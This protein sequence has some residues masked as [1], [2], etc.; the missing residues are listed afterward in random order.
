MKKVLIFTASTGG[1][2]NQAASSLVEEFKNNGYEAFKVDMLKETSSVLNTLITDGYKVLANKMPKVYGG[3]YKLSDFE[4]IN[5]HITSPI[6]KVVCGEINKII[7][8]H[9]PDLI[10]GTHPFIVDIVGK[11]KREKIIDIP[12]ISIVT[13]FEAHQTYINKYVDAYI[14][15]SEY[16]CESLANRGIS[17]A[18]LYPYGIPVKRVFLENNKEK[19]QKDIFQ[20]LL[21]GGS[22]GVKSMNKVFK[23]LLESSN[24]FKLVIVCGNDGDLKKSLESFI[25]NNPIN[26]QIK[27]YGFTDKIAELMDESDIIITKPGGLTVTESIIKN[28]P[29]IIP[30][31]IP[32]QEEENAD[33]LVKSG[34][35]IK[36]S[37]K[38]EIKYIVDYLI[39][40][41][42]KLKDMRDKMKELSKKY[43]IES[44]IELA[45]KLILQY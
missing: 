34:V 29:M 3:L 30:Y 28:I 19:R 13:D 6:T 2:H 43:S 10:I 45:D 25:A 1:G 7:Q 44:I 21:M 40:N 15:G 33:F 9:N 41:P 38:K 42:N 39:E 8:R 11:L 24:N 5:T 18:I 32:G 36:T 14:T 12:F 26:K 22:M 31:L 4:K 16:T 17:R 20:I 23:N 37:D 35:A 27:L